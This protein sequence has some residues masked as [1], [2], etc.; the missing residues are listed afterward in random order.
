MGGK[1]RG[2]VVGQRRR[3]GGCCAIIFQNSCPPTP[4]SFDTP[5]L[6]HL[7]AILLLLQTSSPFSHLT[8]TSCELHDRTTSSGLSQHSV[9]FEQNRCQEG[10]RRR[11][12]KNLIDNSASSGPMRN[13]RVRLR[14]H[15]HRQHR[16]WQVLSPLPALRSKR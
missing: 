1:G 10:R 9:I 3:A 16:H 14:S 5:I 13:K 8:T 4:R 11:R 12:E 2:L 15:K 6:T 7:P